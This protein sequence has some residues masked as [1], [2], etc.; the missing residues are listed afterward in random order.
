[1]CPPGAILGRSWSL[2]GRPGESLGASWAYLGVILSDLGWSWGPLGAMLCQSGRP[3]TLVF[4]RFFNVFVAN[5]ISARKIAMF[6][7]LGAVLGR[8]GSLLGRLGTVLGRSWVVF[9]PSWGF[10][11]RSWDPIGPYGVP[12]LR[13]GI[14]GRAS[15][16]GSPPRAY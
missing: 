16:G 14:C 11:G 13:S 2:L 4:L 15:L 5:P 7:H 12:W 3:K 6:G 9:G 10:L 8:L 1:M